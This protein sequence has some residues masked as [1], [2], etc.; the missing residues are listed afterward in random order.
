[1]NKI[2]PETIKYCYF[3]EILL[4]VENC[5]DSPITIATPLALEMKFE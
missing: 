4:E 2:V 3:Y 1:M 5:T